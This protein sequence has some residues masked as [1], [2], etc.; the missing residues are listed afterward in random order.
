MASDIS[1]HLSLYHHCRTHDQYCSNCVGL[2]RH[3]LLRAHTQTRTIMFP[4]LIVTTLRSPLPFK[5]P[6]R[7]HEYDHAF[8]KVICKLEQGNKGETRAW[9]QGKHILSGSILLCE[10]ELCDVTRTPA[11]DGTCLCDSFSFGKQPSFGL[12]LKA[13]VVIGE[14]AMC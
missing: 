9:E 11:P 5:S 7:A 1:D 6:P 2:R 4:S 13:T 10:L 12:L 8:M 3:A 14:L